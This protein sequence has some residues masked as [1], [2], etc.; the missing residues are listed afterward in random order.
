MLVENKIAASHVDKRPYS[1]WEEFLNTLTHFIGALFSVVALIMLIVKAASTGHATNV[2]AVTIFGVT[3]ISMYVASSIYHG[4]S[5]P[6]LKKIFRT[7]DHVNIYFL[8]AGTYTPIALIAL[9]GVY[10]WIIFSL[11]W[12][13][14]LAGFVYSNLFRNS[15]SKKYK[16]K[17]CKD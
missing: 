5:N 12:A 11:L 17:M 14:A 4:I 7:I 3:L 8:I 1:K 13:A 16:V 9:S 2:V 6:K 10:G 15:R